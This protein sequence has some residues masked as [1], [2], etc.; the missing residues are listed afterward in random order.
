MTSKSKHLEI[1]LLL[2][3]TFLSTM[4]AVTAEDDLTPPFKITTK[5]DKDRVEVKAEKDKVVFSVHS[6]FGISH[7]VIERAGETWP[8]A[9]VLQYV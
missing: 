2:V 5:R 9:V 7:A 3:A 4:K 8:A 1:S 6:P